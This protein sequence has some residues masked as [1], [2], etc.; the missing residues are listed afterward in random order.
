MLLAITMAAG[1]IP[2]IENIFDKIDKDTDGYVTVKEHVRS[3]KHREIGGRAWNNINANKQLDPVQFHTASKGFLNKVCQEQ[4]MVNKYSPFDLDD[5][6][7]F[8]FRSA[9]KKIFTLE[10]FLAA[11]DRPVDDRFLS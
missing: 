1:E 11:A 5:Y 6:V 3:I 10:D 8:G 2:E 9:G 7:P 4:E